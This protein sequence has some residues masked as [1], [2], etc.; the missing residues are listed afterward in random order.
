MSVA[1]MG[2]KR[3][4]KGKRSLGDTGADEISKK[5]CEGNCTEVICLRTG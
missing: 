5:Y 2:N 1:R 3:K 4:P